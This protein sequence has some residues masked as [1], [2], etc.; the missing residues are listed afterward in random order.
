MSEKKVK[1][2]QSDKNVEK[3]VNMAKSDNKEVHVLQQMLLDKEKEIVSLNKN[4]D[5]LE[6]KISEKDKENTELRGSIDLSANESELK[7]NYHA[8]NSSLKQQVQLN[9]LQALQILELEH[10]L[11]QAQKGH[12]EAEEKLQEYVQSSA[13]PMAA[14]DSSVS[15]K[16]NQEDRRKLLQIKEL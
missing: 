3:P 9:R 8:A 4:I 1:S 12:E 16:T 10:A 14:L 5:K 7:Q 6:F 13:A 2:K 15:Q 11:W